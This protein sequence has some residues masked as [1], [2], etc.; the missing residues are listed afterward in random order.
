L[1]E[2]DDPSTADI[3]ITGAHCYGPFFDPNAGTNDT[4]LLHA[5][6]GAVYVQ[7]PNAGDVLAM[8][9]GI[10]ASQYS[11]NTVAV[12]DI[13]NIFDHPESGLPTGIA[14]F[15]NRSQTMLCKTYFF[16]A[17]PGPYQPATEGGFACAGMSPDGFH[18]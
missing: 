10:L 18:T 17:N 4:A 12:K 3:Y 7:T 16:S 2:D 1:T 13:A 5:P 6:G 14:L 9:P 15:K 11:G 8:F